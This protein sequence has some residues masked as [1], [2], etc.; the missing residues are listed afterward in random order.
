LLLEEHKTIS[1]VLDW[2]RN[3]GAGIYG[4]GKKKIEKWRKC[5]DE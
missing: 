4:V 3:D 5:L 2:I 1:R